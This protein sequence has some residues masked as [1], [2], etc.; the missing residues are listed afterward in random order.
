MFPRTPIVWWFQVRIGRKRTGYKIWGV[1]FGSILPLLMICD[2]WWQQVP[3][4]THSFLLLLQLSFL[5]FHPIDQLFTLRPKCISRRCCGPSLLP[6][7]PLC[8]LLL[9]LPAFAFSDKQARHSAVS[10]LPLKPS[11]TQRP[12]PLHRYERSV[13]SHSVVSDSSQPH[14]LYAA[15]LLCSWDFIGKNTGMGWHFLLQGDLPDPGIQPASLTSP[16]LAG[17]FFTTRATWG[18]PWKV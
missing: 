6:Q 12:L 11:L 2:P 4:S 5:T 9:C 1:G 16:A 7:L 13:L 17:G 3:V 18:F 14:G 10:R 15:R 8:W